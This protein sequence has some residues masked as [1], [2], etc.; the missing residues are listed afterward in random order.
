MSSEP[1]TQAPTVT[2]PTGEE[3][4]APAITPKNTVKQR[5]VG[6]VDAQ[7]CS[8]PWQVFLSV[9][10]YMCGGSLISGQWVLT[11]AHCV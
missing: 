7:Q 1:V 5:I 8:L 10:G 3:C 4:T 11:A 2:E 9:G 6:G